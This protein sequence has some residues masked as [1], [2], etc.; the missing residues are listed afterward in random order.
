MKQRASS[1][2]FSKFRNTFIGDREF[3]VTVFAL[4]LPLIV[5]NAISNF[6]NLLDNLMIGQLGTPQMSGVAI[7]NQ[8]IFVFNLAIFGVLSG[9]GIFGAQFFGAGDN[10]GLRHTVRFKLWTV[11]ITLVVS[12]AIFLI[13]GDQL[14][15]LYLT[16]EGDAIQRAATLEYSRSYLHIMLWGLLPFAL[17]Q[18]Y[19]GTLREMGETTLPM[20]ASVA[21]IIT[22]LCLNYMLIYGKLGFPALGVDGAAIATVISR[23]VEVAI[24][25][26]YTHRHLERFQFIEGLYR[27]MK[28]PK[29]LVFKIIKKGIP[30]FVNELLWSLGMTAL[31]QIFSTR[32]LNVIAALNIASTI[33]NL[34]NV[35]V[36]SMGTAVAVMVGQALGANDIPRAKQTAWRLIFFNVCVCIVV[37]ILLAV[38]SPVI[39]YIYNTTDDVRRLATRFM[40][41]NAMYMAVNAVSHCAYFTIRSGGKTFITFLF[42]SVYTWTVFVPFAYVLTHFTSLDISVLYPICCL[43]DVI[44]CIIGIIVV[45]DGRWAQNIVSNT[46]YGGC[47]EP[48]A[49]AV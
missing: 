42:D 35:V 20:K 18:V 12:I 46:V 2:A 44:K 22:N 16:G 5:Q 8:L 30:L 32:G 48:Y 45:K 34:F 26:V 11:A 6:V 7:A 10:E 4:V 39:P 14:I 13:C 49:D 23:F 38:S 31:M 17:S 25:I 27:M 19:G 37:G 43:A 28:I 29:G 40:Q 21:G 36:F 3:Y 9:P 41:T 24:I 15:A 33:T 1:S 47:I